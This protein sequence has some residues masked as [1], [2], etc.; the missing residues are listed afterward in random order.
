MQ[1]YRVKNK[2]NV[3]VEAEKLTPENVDRLANECQGQIVEEGRDKASMKEG[4][5]VKTPNGK[6]RL[7][8]GMYLVKVDGKFY[9]AA[10]VNFEMRYEP[11]VP[12]ET[13]GYPPKM[14]DNPWD[15]IPRIKDVP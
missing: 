13:V 1:K 6:E 15:G 7:H 8:Q 10:A 11:D 3:K 5:N 9:T 2:P 4:V 14:P 12:V